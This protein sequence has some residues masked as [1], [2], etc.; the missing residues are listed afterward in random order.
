[1]YAPVVLMYAGYD[2]VMV[3]TSSTHGAKK[4]RSLHDGALATAAGL[5]L[6]VVQSKLFC[7]PASGAVRT[8]VS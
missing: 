7:G 3:S 6:V 8:G 5:F 4:A 1:M 2:Q